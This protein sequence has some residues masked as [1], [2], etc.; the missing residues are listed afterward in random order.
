MSNRG[1]AYDRRPALRMQRCKNRRRPVAAGRLRVELD[2]IGNK[3]NVHIRFENVARVFRRDLSPRLVDFLEIASYV[4]TADCSAVR[5]KRWTDEHST[6]PWGRDFAF[7]IP[8]REP[9]FWNT[10]KIKGLIDKVLGF[11]S[12]DKYSFSFVSLE[13]DRAAQ[14]P[15]F[16]FGDLGDWPSAVVSGFSCFRE[17][18]IHSPARWTRR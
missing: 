4:F 6:E 15:Y 14:Q 10:A 18:S 8:V 2:S 13:R 7:V 12:N 17:D 11:L 5:G 3:P 16:E 1:R 9:D